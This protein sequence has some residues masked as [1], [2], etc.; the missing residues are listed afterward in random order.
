MKRSNKTK[1]STAFA[2]VRISR[3]DSLEGESNSIS[4]QKQLLT[5]YPHKSNY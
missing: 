3:E 4:T 5:A 1:D 2:Y